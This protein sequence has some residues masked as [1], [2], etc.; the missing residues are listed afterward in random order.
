M[1]VKDHSIYVY[2]TSFSTTFDQI[3]FYEVSMLRY[4]SFYRFNFSSLKEQLSIG[5]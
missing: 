2:F 1:N 3:R 5:F 4:I